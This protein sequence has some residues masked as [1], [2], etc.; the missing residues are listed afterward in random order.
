MFASAPSQPETHGFI[1]GW[2][3]VESGGRPVQT[4]IQLLGLVVLLRL[5]SLLCK[6]SVCH[7]DGMHMRGLGSCLFNQ[8]TSP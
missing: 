4:L 6:R 3:E 8:S 7:I 5:Q 1:P 2:T